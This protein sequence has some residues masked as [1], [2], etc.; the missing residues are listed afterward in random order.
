MNH[1]CV[2]TIRSKQEANLRN[3][4]LNV[5][6]ASLQHK[7]SV[8]DFFIMQKLQLHKPFLGLF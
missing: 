6:V 1:Y 4:D 2:T 5:F 7:L 3:L 8:L